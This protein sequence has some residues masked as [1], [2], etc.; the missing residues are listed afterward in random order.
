MLAYQSHNVMSLLI[1]ANGTRVHTHT[2]V[3]LHTIGSIS[4]P[5]TR[6]R[7]R[8]REREGGKEREWCH[9]IMSTLMIAM[10][11]QFSTSFFSYWIVFFFEYFAQWYAYFAIPTSIPTR[12][13][14]LGLDGEHVRFRIFLST[15]TMIIKNTTPKTTTPI[16]NSNDTIFNW[17]FCFTTRSMSLRA[18]Y[19]NILHVCVF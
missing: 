11:A 9:Q 15:V 7:K 13:I 4:I 12:A 16:S 5:N 6:R 19:F 2:Y 3:L 10:H 18:Q 17:R 1:Y 8:A 14:Q